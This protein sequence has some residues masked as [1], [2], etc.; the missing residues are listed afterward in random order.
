M[1][2]VL[3]QYEASCFVEAGLFGYSATMWLVCPDGDPG[4]C[5]TQ[6]CGSQVTLGVPPFPLVCG[7]VENRC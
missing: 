4:M 6:K 5:Q 3:C 7:A 2:P 1:L